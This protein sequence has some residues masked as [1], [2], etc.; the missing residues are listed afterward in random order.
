MLV[1]CYAEYASSGWMLTQWNCG[2]SGTVEP[3]TMMEYAAGLSVTLRATAPDDCDA[4][5]TVVVG[6]SDDE[7][8]VFAGEDKTTAAT[9]RLF[10]RN[11]L[12]LAVGHLMV[13]DRAALLTALTRLAA[14][15][16][17]PLG[18]DVDNAS[19]A[20]ITEPA[21]P[22]Q[23]QQS[24]SSLLAELIPSATIVKLMKLEYAIHASNSDLS[25]LGGGC[26]QEWIYLHWQKLGGM[27]VVARGK[28]QKGHHRV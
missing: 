6:T 4:S 16:A 23:Q 14:V 10:L 27:V 17:P 19:A 20:A 8:A 11:A 9:P 26:P 21:Q 7:T 22:T 2:H 25:T 12:G 28:R 13:R 3:A 1:D 15:L 5:C 24:H 18:D